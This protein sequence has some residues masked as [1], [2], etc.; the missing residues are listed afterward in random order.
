MRTGRSKRTRGRK[1]GNRT[2]S[3]NMLGL[4]S[5]VKAGGGRNTRGRGNG[6]SAKG[7]GIG[8]VGAILAGVIP[9]LVLWKLL[10]Y[11]NKR[12]RKRRTS[13]KR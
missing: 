6:R 12:V 2:R 1:G 10:K 4:I 5:G 13:K 9:P 3:R 7:G 8:S 11:Q